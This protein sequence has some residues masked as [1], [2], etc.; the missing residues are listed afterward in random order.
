MCFETKYR[1][2]YGKTGGAKNCAKPVQ[3]GYSVLPAVLHRENQLL[4][5]VVGDDDAK[6]GDGKP[7]GCCS[8][9]LLLERKKERVL[10]SSVFRNGHLPARHCSSQR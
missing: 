6:Q 1:K 5:P 3:C 8:F 2:T 10:L 4:E 7:V 9:S